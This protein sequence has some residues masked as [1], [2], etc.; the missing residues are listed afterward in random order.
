MIKPKVQRKAFQALIT[1]NPEPFQ[2]LVTLSTY[3]VPFS[4]DAPQVERNYGALRREYV[5]SGCSWDSGFGQG[6]FLSFLC[7]SLK[8]SEGASIL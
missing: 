5:G 6:R 4:H 2:A 3:T 7:Y 1:L 8:G